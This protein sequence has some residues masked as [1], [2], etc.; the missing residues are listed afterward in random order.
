MTQ[1]TNQEFAQAVAKLTALIQTTK[2]SASVRGQDI[3][4]L[5]AGMVMLANGLQQMDQ[6]VKQLQVD[7]GQWNEGGPSKAS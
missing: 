3:A 6:I 2:T 4:D 7:V 5:A 1:P